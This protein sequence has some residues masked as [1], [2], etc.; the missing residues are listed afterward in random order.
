[1]ARSS[2]GFRP[3]E[4]NCDVSG[5][6]NAVQRLKFEVFY[7][8]FPGRISMTDVDGIVEIGGHFLMLEAKSQNTPLRQGQQILFEQFTRALGT[9]SVV[10]LVQIDASTMT[11]HGYQEIRDGKLGPPES[12]DLESLKSKIRQWAEYADRHR[13]VFNK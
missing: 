6:F 11:V 9:G 7:D 8:C 3:F 1:M 10:Y 4:W 12:A 2:A 5:C 13:K